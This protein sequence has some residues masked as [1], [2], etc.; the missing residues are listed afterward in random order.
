MGIYEDNPLQIR[1]DD[2]DD[3]NITLSVPVDGK[4]PSIPI[5]PSK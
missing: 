3:I 4:M 5:P 1:F 2:I